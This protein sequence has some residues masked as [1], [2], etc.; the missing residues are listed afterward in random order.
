MIG[1][2]AET[3]IFVLAGLMIGLKNIEVVT[4]ENVGKTMLLYV[5]LHVIRFTCLVVLL[6]LLNCSGYPM[7]IRHCALMTWGALRGALA[8]FL[9]LVLDANADIPDKV[10]ALIMFHSSAIAML[11]LVINGTTTG[12]VID[13]L[14]LSKETPT[15]KKFMYFVVQRVRQHSMKK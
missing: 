12:L 13:K 11:T 14:G 15:A 1:F 3:V 6:P 5:L 9:A 7:N 8:I 2:Y 4:W 10:K